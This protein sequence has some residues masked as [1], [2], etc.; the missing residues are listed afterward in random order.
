ML[1]A[2]AQE[3]GP[4]A[5]PLVFRLF[6]VASTL[7]IS[8]LLL[9][10]PRALGVER[11]LLAAASTAGAALFIGARRWSV[12]RTDRASI[13]LLAGAALATYRLGGLAY[14]I[15]LVASAVAA[16]IDRWSGGVRR[17]VHGAALVLSALTLF[18]LG[19]PYSLPLLVPL[20]GWSSST[21]GAAMRHV[22]AVLGAIFTALGM[23]WFAYFLTG[24][25]PVS[26]S[27]PVLAVLVGSGVYFLFAFAIG[28]RDA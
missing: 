22:Y 8:G 25:W 27:I 20:L 12:D 3:F 19:G 28:G 18:S 15:P 17:A 16:T 10:D 7:T 26:A 4:T 23:V 14:L 9:A 21:A 24:R 1:K 13:L 2:T 11:A 5:W 6:S